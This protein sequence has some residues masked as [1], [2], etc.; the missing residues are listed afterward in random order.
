MFD[1]VAYINE[2]RWHTMS[3]GLER[4]RELLA[5]LGDPQDSLR[6]VH[7]AGTNGKGSTCA[8]IARILQEAGYRVGLFT[9]PYIVCFEERIRINGINIGTEDLR[10]V[11][12]QVRDAAEAMTCHPTEFELM[13]A[14]AFLYFAQQHCDIVVAEVG[15]GGR[16]DSTNIISTVEVSVLTP[17]S[18]DHQAMLGNT[19]AEI[20]GEKAGIIKPGIPV[21]SAPQA[22]EV[23]AV[24]RLQA[25]RNHA[26]LTLVCEDEIHGSVHDYSYRAW[27][28]MTLGLEGSYQRINAAVALEACAVLRQRGWNIPDAAIRQGL[29]RVSWPGRF[30]IVHRHPDVII[31]G[32]HNIQAAQALAAELRS[33]YPQQNVVFI[34]GVLRDK[35]YSDMLDVLLPLAQTVMCLTPP[36]PRALSAHDLA[37]VIASKHPGCEVMACASVFEAVRTAHDCVPED[38]VV[39]ACG[40]LYSIGEI[41]AA[42]PQVWPGCC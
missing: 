14:V 13:T 11:T 42:L 21:V 2:P 9:S 8:F 32:A 18:F 27:H 41:K 10:A 15:L 1:P 40:S 5:R 24:F 37:A 25:K 29:A 39:C 31:D 28:T 30:E 3:L 4:I 6:F 17:L 12:E 19:L 35:D 33:R 7:G 20:A 36:N 38:G 16:L 26:P 34:L 22:P 23:E